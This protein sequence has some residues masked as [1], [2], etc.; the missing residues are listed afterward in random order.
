MTIL[1]P[2]ALIFDVFGSLVDWRTGVGNYCQ[3]V[4]EEKSIKQDPLEFADF[5][6]AE[7]QP[8]MNKIRSGNR[9]YIPLD[10]LHRENLNVILDH[11]GHASQFSEVER[12]SLNHAW[13][14]LPPWPDVLEGLS[15]IRKKA[16]IAPC[17]NGSIALMLRLAR[18]AHFNWDAILGAD[19]AKDYK[20]KPDVYLASC[21]ALG[22]EPK[23]VM[24]VAAHNNDLEAARDS[25]LM[26][27]F[28]PRPTE[29]GD[30]QT[31]DLEASENWDIVAENLV[32]LAN[33]I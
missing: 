4:F 33:K 12:I 5:W 28:F 1:K 22:L 3:T 2:K 32:D 31:E 21:A 6:R 18:Y 29:Y 30:S 20:P 25:G 11:T 19:I 16:L 24:M 15:R 26:T 27:A 13:E 8:A 10:I 17:S 14:H 7:Y 9:G 23:E